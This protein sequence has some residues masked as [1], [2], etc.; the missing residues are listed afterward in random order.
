MSRRAPA[1]R[2]GALAALV[3]A[4][5][6][7][8]AGDRAPLSAL[9]VLAAPRDRTEPPK[10]YGVGGLSIKEHAGAGRSYIEASAVEAQ[11]YC[12]ANGE[13][14][15]QLSSSRSGQAKDDEL[16]RFVEKDGKATF[17]R[18][19][20]EIASTTNDAWTKSRA[21]IELREVAK[22]RGITVWGFREANGDV[23][24][25][26]RGATGGREV[27]P[28]KPDADSLIEFISSSCA[29]GAARLSTRMAKVG[30]VA[31]LSGTLPPVGEGKAKVFPRFVIDASLV[32]VARDPEP[33]LSVRIR[34]LE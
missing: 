20:Y 22:A 21:R 1:R 12:I 7:A 10:D 9:P 15:L 8:G 31:Q 33:V 30:G 18:T 4:A 32:K 25:L 17:E 23:V 24:L 34:V 6:P 19:R 5:A 29:Y 3:L 27:R 2:L 16:W 13:L 26:A 14:G 11:G 28:K